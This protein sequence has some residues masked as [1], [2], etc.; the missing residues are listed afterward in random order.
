MKHA[1][2][3]AAI[4][5]DKEFARSIKVPVGFF[6][7]ILMILVALSV[8]AILRAMGIVLA[9]SLLSIPQITASTFARKFSH[10]IVYSTIITIV[11]CLSGLYLSYHFNIP[12]GAAI[13]FIAIVIYALSKTIKALSTRLINRNIIT[14]HSS[15]N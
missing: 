3:I 2:K 6:E 14:P 13:V 12:S 5:F 11:D 1:T 8:V 7:N 10:T 15:H 9:I 4:A